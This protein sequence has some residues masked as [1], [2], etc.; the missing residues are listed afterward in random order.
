MTTAPFDL[1]R[2]IFEDPPD[3]LGE[4]E[5]HFGLLVV[6]MGGMYGV[7][8][9]WAFRAAGDRL[10]DTALARRES[11]EAAYPI[12]FCYRHALEV[13]LK[14]VIPGTKKQHGLDKLWDELHPHV[15]G[16]FRTD[17]LNWLRDR[18]MEFHKIDPR[19]TAFRYHDVEPQG[20]C[21]LWVDFHHL[22]H[23]VDLMFQALERVRLHLQ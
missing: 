9:A 12:L 22:K 3:G 20:Q 15:E 5:F 16:R 4:Q 13:F 6:G 17:H 18:I 14:A 8:V 7:E 2:L 11:W 21:E 19:S 10:L 1:D 23:K